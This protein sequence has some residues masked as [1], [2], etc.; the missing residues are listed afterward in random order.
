MISVHFENG[1]KQYSYIEGYIKCVGLSRESLIAEIDDSPLI[2]NTCIFNLESAFSF[3]ELC[4]KADEILHERYENKD[5]IDDVQET[6]PLCSTPLDPKDSL[7]IISSDD[8]IDSDCEIENVEETK[9]TK[10]KP[11]TCA[12]CCVKTN[13]PTFQ[14]LHTCSINE[15]RKTFINRTFYDNHVESHTKHLLRETNNNL[16]S[17]KNNFAKKRLIEPS[18]FKC[19][20]CMEEF[21][22][23]NSFTE[24]MKVHE[25]VF[26]CKVKSCGRAYPSFNK[27]KRHILTSHEDKSGL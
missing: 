3:R 21:V 9:P 4:L 2:C 11:C 27:L 12:R 14:Q 26:K 7:V 16:M 20:K 22:N 10:L 15:C 18:K 8:D 6:E 25:N 19:E 24:H 13:K 1:G 23:K 17:N 5:E